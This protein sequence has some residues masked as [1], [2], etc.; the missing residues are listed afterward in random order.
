[1][2][3]GRISGKGHLERIVLTEENDGALLRIEPATD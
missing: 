1:M 2:L 3:I